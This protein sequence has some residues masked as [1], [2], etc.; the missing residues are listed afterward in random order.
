MQQA[1]HR[2]I[3]PGFHRATGRQCGAVLDAV[4]H[5]LRIVD[6]QGG[7]DQGHALQSE[8]RKGGAGLETHAQP[9]GQPHVALPRQRPVPRQAVQGRLRHQ[10]QC[11]GERLEA[12]ALQR[13]CE[14]FGQALKR[15]RQSVQLHR[16]L[17]GCGIGLA[18][19]ELR[20][21]HPVTHRQAKPLA[22]AAHRLQGDVVKLD[23]LPGPGPQVLV[24]H[25]H[26]RAKRGDPGR[27]LLSG[28]ML[29]PPRPGEC[30]HDD[31]DQDADHDRS[32][33]PLTAECRARRQP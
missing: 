15:H 2:G 23:G 9:R 5:T 32:L 31:D 33:G 22:P 13:Q 19:G 25:Q 29:Q 20:R 24:A 8:R 28:A 3:G 10:M 6:A 16:A 26:V 18:P 7:I 27:D 30:Q 4:K 17:A 14:V 1:L 11:A 12:A 21:A